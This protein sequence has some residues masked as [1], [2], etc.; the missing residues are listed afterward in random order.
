MHGAISQ[1]WSISLR[2]IN[3]QDSPTPRS[4]HRS[5]IKKYIRRLFSAYLATSGP[6]SSSQAPTLSI[7][8]ISCQMRQARRSAPAPTM[9]LTGVNLSLSLQLASLTHHRLSSQTNH[10]TRSL[11]PRG[12]KTHLERWRWRLVFFFLFF[13]LQRLPCSSRP[14]I[15]RTYSYHA[16]NAGL[17]MSSSALAWGRSKHVSEIRE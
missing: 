7:S 8:T 15:K 14:W 2:M 3:T 4:L 1:R 9:Q 13:F 5:W 6:I 16:N 17:H 10:S 12:E 11:P